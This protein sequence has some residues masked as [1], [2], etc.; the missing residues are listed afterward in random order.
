MPSGRGEKESPARGAGEHLAMTVPVPFLEGGERAPHE[1][2]GSPSQRDTVAGQRRPLT[3][4]PH[5]VLAMVQSYG[6]GPCA[7]YCSRRL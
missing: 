6:L 5:E 2:P 4:F 1:R 7:E 3:G